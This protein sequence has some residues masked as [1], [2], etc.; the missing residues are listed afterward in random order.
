[1]TKKA[2]FISPVNIFDKKGNGGAKA[3]FEHLKML[4]KVYGKDNVKIILFVEQNESLNFQQNELITLFQKPKSSIKLLLASFWG[5]RVYMPWEEKSIIRKINAFDPEI[6]FFDY[7][8]EGRLVKKVEKYKKI[9]F[10]H[11]VEADYTYNRMKEYGWHLFPAYVAAIIND[12]WAVKYADTLLCFND[13]DRKRILQK[14][15]KNTDMCIPITFE[16]KFV[17][18]KICVESKK[19][20]LF[21]GSCFGPNIDGVEWFVKNVM[22]Q[23]PDV[24][25]YIVGKGF[26]FIKDKLELYNNIHVVGTVD[27]PAD[28]YYKYRLVV[29][30]IRY[31]AGM[32]VKTAEAMMYGCHILASDEALEGYEIENVHGID[33]C[34]TATEYINAINEYFDNRYNEL[35][36]SEVRKLFLNKYETNRVYKEFKKVIKD[37]LYG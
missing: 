4:Q 31:G 7:S 19:S 28:Y 18:S 17:E 11:N 36:E 16:D 14:Y 8:V 22:Q 25:L 10:F 13:R 15:L 35:F 37:T 33:R 3:S 6:V 24:S 27:C 29:M 30:P 34:N 1:M 26:E 12:R 21:L 2:V 20:I 23:I 9:V 5:C 32:K